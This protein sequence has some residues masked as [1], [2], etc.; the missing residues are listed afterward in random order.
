MLESA[1]NRLA[2]LRVGPFVLSEIRYSPDVRQAVHAHADAGIT[3]VLG[4]SLAER[5]GSRHEI[6]HALSIVVKPA[7][8]QHAN[9]I[10]DAGAHTFQLCFSP[11]AMSPDH[12]MSWAWHHGGF[13]LREFVRLLELVRSRRSGEIEA[14]CFD[15]LAAA[16]KVESAAGEPPRWLTLVCEHINDLLPQRVQVRDLAD[17]AGVHP[18]YLARQFRRFLGCTV[19]DFIAA[20]RLQF[21][22]AV[23][24]QPRP[25]LAAVAFRAGYADQS[26]LTRSFR[27]AAGVTPRQFRRLIAGEVASRSR[28]SGLKQALLQGNL[29][30]QGDS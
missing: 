9:H 6:A 26:H 1:V 21:A 15:L 2:Q 16:H 23:I 27:K 30:H 18:V 12:D 7:D 20:R 24:Q 28:K 17:Y 14:A 11:H 3:L 5:V 4:G 10:G 19:T 13:M 25:Q 8:T 22:A 29:Q